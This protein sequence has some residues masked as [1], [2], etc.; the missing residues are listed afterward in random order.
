MSLSGRVFWSSATSVI[1]T[2][3]NGE[4]KQ[5]KVPANVKFDVD[6]RNMTAAQ[7]QRGMKITATK[8]VEEPI[9]QI[10]QEAVVTGTAPQ[11]Q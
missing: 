7:L 9:S 2:L 8:V 1:L 3:D 6:G 10:S 5:Y 11:A 4:N